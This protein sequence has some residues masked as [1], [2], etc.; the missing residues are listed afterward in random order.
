M[1]PSVRPR[2]NPVMPIRAPAESCN[3]RTGRDDDDEEE[4][5]VND[6]DNGILSFMCLGFV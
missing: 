5:D 3:E 1:E 4:D 2:V 6:D